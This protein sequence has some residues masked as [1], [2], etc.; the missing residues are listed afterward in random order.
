M[1]TG[2]GYVGTMFDEFEWSRKVTQRCPLWITELNTEAIVEWIVE[3]ADTDYG[4]IQVE[5]TKCDALDRPFCSAAVTASVWALEI[6]ES[7]GEE[8]GSYVLQK[9][10]HDFR[11]IGLAKRWAAAFAEMAVVEDANE[12]LKSG[13]TILDEDE[14]WE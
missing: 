13:F 10:K 5:Y 6:D 2:F 12:F 11:H 4:S 7:L 1:S 8:V 14:G 3:R 9:V